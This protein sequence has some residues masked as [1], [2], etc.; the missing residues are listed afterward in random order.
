MEYQNKV[1]ITLKKSL[2]AILLLGGFS[3]AA[4]VPSEAWDSG[5]REFL[6]QIKH[7][8]LRQV[9]QSKKD[10]SQLRS[11]FAFEKNCEP[12]LRKNKDQIRKGIL[13]RNEEYRLLVGLS[14]GKVDLKQLK[15]ASLGMGF[16]FVSYERG[17]FGQMSAEI[18]DILKIHKKDLA[19]IGQKV[20]PQATAL[21]ASHAQPYVDIQGQLV[22]SELKKA[23]DFYR[24]QAMMLLTQVPFVQFIKSDRPTDAE[25]SVAMGLY[26]QKLEG[27]LVNLLDEKISPLESFLIYS[28]VVQKVLNKDIQY[29]KIYESI[30]FQQSALVGFQAW[31]ERNSPSIKLAAFSTCSFVAAVLQAWPV[32][33]GCGGALFALTSKQLYFDYN[34]MKET[35]VLWMEGVETKEHFQEV[36]GRLLYSSLSLLLVGQGV[37]STIMS[38][39]LSLSAVLSQLPST[40]A[41]RFTSLSALRDGSLRFAERTIENKGKDLGASLMGGAYSEIADPRVRISEKSE[42]LFSYADFLKLQGVRR[43]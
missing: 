43:P 29:F 5:Q 39:E 27:V 10:L 6:E 11:C 32:S 26:Y 17:S 1:V 35:F 24:M 19:A 8:T 31:V 22:V 14:Q 20:A 2:G 40:A 16:S 34:K 7:E 38:I 30:R 42:R 23:Q 36:R 41:A 21:S 37:S 28:P 25:I 3:S 13:Q 33:L 4:S 12:D 9:E 18:L 15:S